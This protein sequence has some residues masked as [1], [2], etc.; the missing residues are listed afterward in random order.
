MNYPASLLVFTGIYGC[1]A[2][3]P[4]TDGHPSLSLLISYRSS[5]FNP[6]GLPVQDARRYACL[7]RGAIAGLG[8]DL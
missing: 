6:I 3:S 4:P 7:Y 2:Q 1:A 5:S 8:G